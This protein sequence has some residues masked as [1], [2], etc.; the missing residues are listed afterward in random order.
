MRPNM[1]NEI[2]WDG[3]IPTIIEALSEKVHKIIIQEDSAPAYC[4]QFPSINDYF[5]YFHRW[6]RKTN[7]FLFTG[8]VTF[9]DNLRVESLIWY[10]CL[11]VFSSRSSKLCVFFKNVQP[12]TVYLNLYASIALQ[13]QLWSNKMS[14]N[15]PS[16]PRGWW[17]SKILGQSLS[18]FPNLQLRP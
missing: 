14:R 3:L 16:S 10:G 4:A 11:N 15:S 6:L 9:K 7:I 1:C 2:L 17:F 12:K 8:C 18:Y 5:K 13:A